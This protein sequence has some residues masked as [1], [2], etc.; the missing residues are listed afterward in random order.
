[1]TTIVSALVTEETWK[2]EEKEI[3]KTVII[4]RSILRN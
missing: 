3:G 4:F 2:K 1:M